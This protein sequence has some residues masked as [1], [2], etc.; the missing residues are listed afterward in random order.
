VCV[1]VKDHP[2]VLDELDLVH[3]DDQHTHFMSLLEGDMDT[4]DKLS[5]LLLQEEGRVCGMAGHCCRLSVLMWL[6]GRR[7]PC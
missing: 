4:E 5:E 3:E 2:S 6:C 7:V 1:V